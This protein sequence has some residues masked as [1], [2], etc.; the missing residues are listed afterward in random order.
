MLRIV[1]VL[2]A[3]VAVGLLGRDGLRAAETGTFAPQALGALWASLDRESLLLFE[4]AVTRYLDPS[5]WIYIV[6]PVL[7]APAFLFFL[8]VALLFGALWLTFRQRRRRNL[9]D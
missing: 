4:P 1:A 9:L 5:V 7:E 3:I 2:F 8:G 6:Q